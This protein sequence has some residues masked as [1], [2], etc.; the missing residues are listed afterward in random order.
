AS[1]VP[2][3]TLVRSKQVAHVVESQL[4]REQKR[5][6]IARDLVVVDVLDAGQEYHVTHAVVGGVTEDVVR[7]GDHLIHYLVRTTLWLGHQVIKYPFKF[8]N[9]FA[10]AVVVIV[11][12]AS[13]R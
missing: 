11:N 6:A 7:V 2:Y 12:Y 3:T 10:G 4:N 8:Q 13:D 5:V 1:L 9:L